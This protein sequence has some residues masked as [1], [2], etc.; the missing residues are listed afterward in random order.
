MPCSRKL[1]AFCKQLRSGFAENKCPDRFNYC[2]NMLIFVD[3][4]LY[5][6]GKYS[7]SSFGRHFQTRPVDTVI[8]TDSFSL[9]AEG[10]Y[11]VLMIISDKLQ[12]SSLTS[13]VHLVVYIKI[14]SLD[15]GQ[16]VHLYIALGCESN[17]VPVF[18]TNNA[19]G[20][21]QSKRYLA[22]FLPTVLSS[23]CL[24]NLKSESKTIQMLE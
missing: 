10:T 22:V 13:L 20:M 3:I 17:W 16:H 8:E 21:L 1:I 11:I 6:M 14:S 5:L 15:E 12:T 4:N 19:S 7:C 2:A 18:I 23:N 24:T 9:F